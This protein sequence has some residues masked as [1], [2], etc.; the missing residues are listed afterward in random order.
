[1]GFDTHLFILEKGRHN[2]E[3]NWDTKKHIALGHASMP[4][5]KED[6]PGIGARQKAALLFREKI[7]VPI[8]NN[9]SVENFAPKITGDDFN[10]K[11]EAIILSDYYRPIIWERDAKE[12]NLAITSCVEMHNVVGRKP[13]L[14]FEAAT[15]YSWLTTESELYGF[16]TIF[17]ADEEAVLLYQLWKVT[18]KNAAKNDARCLFVFNSCVPAIETF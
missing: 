6:W 8:I 18:I 4:V 11:G 2:P 12:H 7:H 15:V 9:A 16:D 14:W 10:D 1:M 13:F 5:N 17:E 3:K